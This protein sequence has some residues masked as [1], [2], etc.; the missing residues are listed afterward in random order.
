MK[1]AAMPTHYA[2]ASIVKPKPLGENKSDVHSPKQAFQIPLYSKN[3]DWPLK[4]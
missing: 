1:S 2:A 4:E 3:Q